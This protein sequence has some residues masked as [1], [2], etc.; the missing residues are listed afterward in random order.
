MTNKK[1]GGKYTSTSSST[2]GH[3]RAHRPSCLIEWSGSL[4][5]SPCICVFYGSQW[6]GLW[7]SYRLVSV[8]RTSYGLMNQWLGPTPA[9]PLPGHAAEMAQ[10][11]GF[12]SLYSVVP[13]QPAERPATRKEELSDREKLLYGITSKP[14]T[15]DNFG[16]QSVLSS[17][18]THMPPL[19][20]DRCSTRYQGS[21]RSNKS[22]IT[23]GTGVSSGHN[24]L[25][26]D[27]YGV[28]IHKH[29]LTHW[30]LGA[31]LVQWNESLVGWRLFISMQRYRQNQMYALK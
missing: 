28:S 7:F 18:Q 13:F 20:D 19:N 27:L 23:G 14:N 16:D 21:R 12:R 6:N 31:L 22:R 29:G 10:E 2:S 1:N 30:P 8:Y 5:Y 15:R 3:G 4:G 24:R 25:R 11:G 9:S 26:Q 17:R